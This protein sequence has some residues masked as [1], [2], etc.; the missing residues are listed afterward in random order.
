MLIHVLVFVI[1]ILCV[2]I[3]YTIGIENMNLKRKDQSQAGIQQFLAKRVSLPAVEN[4]QGAQQQQ[5]GD[6]KRVKSRAPPASLHQVRNHLG[7]CMKCLIC[8]LFFCRDIEYF[9]TII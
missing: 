3:Y 9:K 7:V 8:Y 6:Q 5:M 1:C 2:N 4:E